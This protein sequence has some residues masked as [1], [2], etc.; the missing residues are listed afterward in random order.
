MS[1]AYEK[2][3]DDDDDAAAIRPV[4]NSKHFGALVRRHNAIILDRFFS[5]FL[6]G[7]TTNEGVSKKELVEGQ[8]VPLKA[9]TTHLL[10]AAALACYCLSTVKPFSVEKSSESCRM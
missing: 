2:P 6:A 10:L 1:T 3:P 4:R 5:P 7:C 9:R 8:Y